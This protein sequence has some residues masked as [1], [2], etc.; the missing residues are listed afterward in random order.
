MILLVWYLSLA[1]ERFSLYID[2][3]L[4]LFLFF[5]F[6][7]GGRGEGFKIFA[8]SCI[9]II[10][11]IVYFSSHHSANIFHKKSEESKSVSLKLCKMQRQKKTKGVRE[12]LGLLRIVLK[13]CR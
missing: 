12:V 10:F 8:N 6:G 1:Q 2:I 7:G 5:F 9:T 13:L 11:K 3:F 4:F